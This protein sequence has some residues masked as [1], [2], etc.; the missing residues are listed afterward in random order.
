MNSILFLVKAEIR[1]REN[2]TPVRPRHICYCFVFE[3]E[4]RC[5]QHRGKKYHDSLLSY[6]ACNEKTV[7]AVFV[8]N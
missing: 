7:F 2:G 3:T 5:I 1:I 4:E 8:F 6:C